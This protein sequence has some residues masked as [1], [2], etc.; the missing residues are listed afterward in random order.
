M[1]ITDIIKNGCFLLAP[2]A[3]VAD[4]AFRTICIRMGADAVYTEMVSAKA[5]C[6]NDSKT[7]SL[8]SV[9]PEEKNVIAQIFGHEP[10]IMAKAASAI[11]QT[12]RFCAIDINFGCPMPKITG[13]GDGSALLK[14]IPLAARIARQVARAVTLPVT[15]K[16]RLGWER[17]HNI[18]ADMAAALEDA[19]IAAL[20]VHARYKDQLYSPPVDYNA[21]GLVRERVKIP[22]IA[23]GDITCYES[24]RA[25]LRQTGCQSLMIG[26]GAL[27]NP[28]VFNEIKSFFKTGEVAY[29]PFSDKMTAVREHIALMCEYKGEARALL[30]A[31]KHVSWYLKGFP[32]AAAMR[33]RINSL[34]RLCDLEVLLDRAV[35]RDKK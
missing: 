23:N 19:G 8:L 7:I 32:G 29:T 9:S 4:S 14:D 6:Y 18:S 25:A 26:R 30:E 16:I 1:N 28:F 17:P 15:A 34:K 31:R 27:G 33:E 24:A 10:E 22:V 13:N 20:C 35:E 5:L 2:M 21:V 3:G 11:E 12:G